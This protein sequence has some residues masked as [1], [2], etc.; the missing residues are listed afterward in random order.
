ME[1]MPV[2]FGTGIQRWRFHTRCAGS[3]PTTSQRRNGTLCTAWT[4][5]DRTPVGN[6]MRKKQGDA[7]ALALQESRC[8]QRRMGRIQTNDPAASATERDENAPK[9][10][11]TNP[12]AVSRTRKQVRYMQDCLAP[13]NLAAPP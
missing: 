2:H 12:S 3:E 11:K 13:T 5:H 7:D 9:P 1:R 6:G 4:D 8:N 10:A